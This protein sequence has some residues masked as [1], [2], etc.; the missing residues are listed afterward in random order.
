M[1]ASLAHHK[2]LQRTVKR[3]A[4]IARQRRKV[5][6][7]RIILRKELLL[8]IDEEA[9]GYAAAEAGISNAEVRQTAG[10]GLGGRVL[11]RRG[12]DVVD[13][14]VVVGVSEFLRRVV[15]DFREDEGG[16]GGRGG[17]G[18]GGV[19]REDGGGVGYACTGVGMSVCICLLVCV[20]VCGRTVGAEE[21]VGDSDSESCEY[22]S[23]SP[24]PSAQPLLCCVLVGE[25]SWD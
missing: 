14:E 18:R 1:C 3:C 17:G 6:N 10:A 9:E 13:V 20:P 19:F 15:G 24:S 22:C 5:G 2:L 16:E 11:G 8:Q 21:E 4:P 12:R 7:S 23:S 25:K